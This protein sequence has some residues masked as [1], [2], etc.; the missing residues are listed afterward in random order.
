MRYLKVPLCLMMII[1]LSGCTKSRFMDL[2]GFVENYNTLGEENIALTDFIYRQ[3]DDRE[4]KLIKDNILITLKQAPDRKIKECRVMLMKLDERGNVSESLS[5]DGEIF[6]AEVIKLL[7]AYCA[8][9]RYTA[10]KLAGELSLVNGADLMKQ[11]ELTKKQDNFYIVYYSTSL[12]SQIMI[13]DTYL[14]EI[15]TTKKPKTTLAEEKSH[16]SE[17]DDFYKK[18]N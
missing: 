9:D 3:G 5:Q 4:Y 8:Y 11:G 1:L 17:T 15:E 18:N 7:Q 12:V 16:P 6:V 10:E 2:S 14:T 13:Y